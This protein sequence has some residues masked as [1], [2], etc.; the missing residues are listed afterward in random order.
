M[1][2]VFLIAGLGADKRLFKN[3][4]IPEGYEVVYADWLEPNLTDTLAG[5]AQ[6]IISQYNISDYDIAIGVSLGGVISTEIAKRVNLRKVILISSIKTDS[7]APFYFNVFRKIPVYKLTSGELFNKLGFV[8][9][10]VFGSMSKEDQLLFKSMLS[11]SSPVFLKWAM[12]A[13]LNW[14]NDV[15]PPN[16]YHIIGDKDLVFP[17]KNIKNPTAV[18]KGGTHIIVFDRAEEINTLLADILIP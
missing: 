13:V 18:I 17:Y 10:L 12:G 9:R 14:R 15:I 16:L 2:K 7:E 3:I 11:N 6:S 4:R 5:Y 1:P 8:V